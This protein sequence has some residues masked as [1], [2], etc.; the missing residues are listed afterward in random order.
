[1]QLAENS[2][3]GRLWRTWYGCDVTL[4]LHGSVISECL[5]HQSYQSTEIIEVLRESC[6]P[7][8]IACK[9]ILLASMSL[10]DSTCLSLNKHPF[11]S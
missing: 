4:D 11:N 10:A 1:M 3:S 6:I 2:T 9:R 8:L 7:L 5:S